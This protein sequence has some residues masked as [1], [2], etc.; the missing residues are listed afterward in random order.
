[1]AA[2]QPRDRL[3]AAAVEQAHARFVGLYEPANP[4]ASA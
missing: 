4:D 1:M 2:L 3:L